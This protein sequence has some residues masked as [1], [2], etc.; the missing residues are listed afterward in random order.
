[1]E[2]RE[3]VLDMRKRLI[4][5]PIDDELLGQLD[6]LSKARKVPRAETIRAACRSLVLQTKEAEL[7]RRYV[8]SYKAQ[9]E[10]PIWGE[11]G[12]LLAAE[13]WGQEDWDEP[14]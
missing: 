14:G 3:V 8:E 12:A 6:L 1:M 13:V 11:V 10:A 4:Q 7:E 2:Y 5:V 9:P